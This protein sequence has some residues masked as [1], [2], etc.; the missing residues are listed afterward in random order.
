MHGY[1][2]WYGSWVSTTYLGMQ[3]YVHS[4]K[5]MYSNLFELELEV[6]ARVARV[7]KDSRDPFTAW[8]I[9]QNVNEV[10][11]LEIISHVWWKN[12][13]N[14]EHYIIIGYRIII[15]SFHNISISPG[16][17]TKTTDDTWEREREQTRVGF[18]L[19]YFVS[20]GS[21]EGEKAYDDDDLVD[22]V[23]K[24]RRGGGGEKGS[25]SPISYVM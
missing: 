6:R 17:R 4:I 20:F 23:G 19:L 1:M 18:A 24:R 16:L 8:F 12:W 2:I 22:W 11:E 13:G 5:E 10:P 9:P 3:L 7:T 25:Q 21:L 15:I 14:S